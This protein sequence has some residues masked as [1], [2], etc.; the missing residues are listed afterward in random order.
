VNIER[1]RLLFSEKNAK[2]V[3]LEKILWCITR[4]EIGRMTALKILSH[5]VRVVTAKSTPAVTSFQ[6]WSGNSDIHREVTKAQ[7]Y[8]LAKLLPMSYGNEWIAEKTMK[9]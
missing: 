9:M 8:K 4:T 5:F 3:E 1:K 6:T 7:L 2:D